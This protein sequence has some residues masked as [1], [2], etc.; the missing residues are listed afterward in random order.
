MFIILVR[1]YTLS[2][3]N[4]SRKSRNSFSRNSMLMFLTVV[5]SLL[6]RDYVSF[7]GSLQEIQNNV[8][9]LLS[10]GSYCLKYKLH[11]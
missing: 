7:T 2:Y 10:I 6:K 3:V 9:A 5:C 8:V 4:I 1:L 11:L